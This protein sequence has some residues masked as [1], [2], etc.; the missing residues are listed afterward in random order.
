[1]SVPAVNHQSGT[2]VIRNCECRD[3][4]IREPAVQI[5]CIGGL[6]QGQQKGWASYGLSVLFASA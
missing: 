1:M 2:T 4:D 3:D 6:G 5:Q